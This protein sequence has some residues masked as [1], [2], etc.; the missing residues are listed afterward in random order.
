LRETFSNLPLFRLHFSSSLHF[1]HKHIF[2]IR[3][4]YWHHALY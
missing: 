4:L 2:T 3:H 1:S